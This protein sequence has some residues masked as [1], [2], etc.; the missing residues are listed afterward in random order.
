VAVA[1]GEHRAIL[2][3]QRDLADAGE[4]R[5]QIL[6]DGLRIV[7]YVDG[8][9]VGNTDIGEGVP[10][11]GN[12]VGILCS[13]GGESRIRRFEAHPVHVRLPASLDMGGPWVRKGTEIVAADD[14]GGARA[15]LDGRRTPT[16][17]L[18]WKR[19][20]GQGAI[21]ITGEG[22][23]RVK[24]PCPGR[25]AYC[26]DWPREDFVDVEVTL[27]PPG[28]AAGERQRTTAGFILYQDPDNFMT[29]NAYRADS[30][31]G[32][33]M[34]TFFK[35][36]GFEDIYDAIWSNVFDRIFYGKRAR[37]RVCCDGEQYAVFI[38]DEAVLY[39]KFRDV[40]PGVDRL[41]I[42]KVGIL[43]NWEF[44]TDTGTVFERC[45]MRY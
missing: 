28:R 38:N 17:G 23:A 41:S 32:G 5:L 20:I 27:V 33:S 9:A 39:R 12:G 13:D 2:T 11:G 42:R 7:A 37:L 36:N 19:T 14:F 3:G 34:S 15:D 10:T 25:T 6:D 18:E 22:Y 40:Y 43:A 31:G 16:G 24:T 35:F 44:G 26:V 1:G 29:L 21:E 30:Y 4:H 8:E 45:T